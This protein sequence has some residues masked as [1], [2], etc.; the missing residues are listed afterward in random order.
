MFPFI[1]ASDKLGAGE[2]VGIVIALV[3]VALLVA[4]GVVLI[5]KRKIRIPGF[6]YSEFEDESTGIENPMYDVGEYGS[7]NIPVNLMPESGEY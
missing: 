7:A 3:V 2:I 6:S 1:S 4:M 5:K